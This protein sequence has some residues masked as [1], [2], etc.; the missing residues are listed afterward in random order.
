MTFS[1]SFFKRNKGEHGSNIARV[2]NIY[3]KNLKME[4]KPS[5]G[6]K[7]SANF[8]FY[9]IPHCATSAAEERRR[10]L[11]LSRQKSLVVKKPV[12]S[13]GFPPRPHTN[14]AVQPHNMARG[15]EFHTYEVEALYYLCSENK[16]ADRLCDYRTANLRLCFRICGNPVFS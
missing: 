7:A 3:S 10:N 1:V 2:N 9:S 12:L 5:I 14:Q 6:Q 11:R 8:C 13:S 16:G 15:L 4:T